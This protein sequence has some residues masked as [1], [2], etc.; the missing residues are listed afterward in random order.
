M[1]VFRNGKLEGFDD[2]TV[3]AEIERRRM[4]SGNPGNAPQKSI[5]QAEIETLLAHKPFANHEE[6]ESD[7]SV[8]PLPLRADRRGAM[9]KVDRVVLVDRLREVIAQVGFTR[10]DS[11]MADVDGELNLKV[12]LAPLAREMSWVPAVEN[13]GEGFLVSFDSKALEAWETR[14]AVKRRYQALQAGYNAWKRAHPRS[15]MAFPS[16][17]YILLHTLSHLLISSV[18]LSCGYAASAIRERV[19]ATEAG[20]GI[21][22]Y[23]GTPD[24]E[25]TLGGLVQVGTRIEEHLHAAI[26]MAML[27]SNDPVCGQHR[28]ESEHEARFLHGAACHGCLL[29]AEPSCERRNEFLDRA[30]LVPTVEPCGA[31]FFEDGEG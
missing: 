18:S 1:L 22:L 5:K 13:R 30:L 20:S 7:F 10:F 12:H 8:R 4:L 15:N 27:C 11:A 26:E 28:P 25:G 23:T 2:E 17:R 31:E 6:R 24:A 16:A 9:G 29:I 19:Y 3:F 14:L 21:L